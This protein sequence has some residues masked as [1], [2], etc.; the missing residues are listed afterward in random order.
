MTDE[1]AEPL[2][3]AEERVRVLLH[4]FSVEQVPHGDELDA[5]GR[6]HGALAAARAARARGRS[7]RP[8]RRSAAAL[9]SLVR[10]R[11]GR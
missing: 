2:T 10:G 5:L 6:P 3:P 9:G 1:D 8:A 11:R 4:P 7:G